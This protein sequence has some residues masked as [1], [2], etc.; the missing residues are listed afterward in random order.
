MYKYGDWALPGHYFYKIQ[1][2]A[3]FLTLPINTARVSE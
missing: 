3:R 1:K 2:R